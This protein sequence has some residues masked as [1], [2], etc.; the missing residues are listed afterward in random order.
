MADVVLK[1]PSGSFGSSLCVADVCKGDEW[2]ESRK[3]QDSAC[4][5]ADTI[6]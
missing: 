5:D 6:K 4:T 3:N 1:S 2:I